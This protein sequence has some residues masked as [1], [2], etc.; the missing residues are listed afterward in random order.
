MHFNFIS[1]STNHRIE[2]KQKQFPFKIQSSHSIWKIQKKL[3]SSKIIDVINFQI[4][5][6]AG[7]ARGMDCFLISK[8]KIWIVGIY[9]EFLQPVKK[10]PLWH[11][12]SHIRFLLIY[13]SSKVSSKML[14][15]CISY[16]ND[17][18]NVNICMCVKDV[19]INLIVIKK[20]L[21]IK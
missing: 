10:T 16:W 17:P 9:E 13:R 6:C 11:A 15:I 1:T 4:P 20:Y 19:L 5:T 7:M 12:I 8:K 2:F 14:S 21:C 3:K 18:K